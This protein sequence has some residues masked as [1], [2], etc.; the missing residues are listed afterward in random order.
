MQKEVLTEEIK[1]ELEESLDYMNEKYYSKWGEST[2]GSFICTSVEWWC[3]K[4]KKIA[5]L[6]M[7]ALH[8]AINE[9]FCER[10]SRDLLKALKDI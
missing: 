6:Y 1:K 8:K 9:M 7:D 5:P 4:N 10:F 2:F 3:H